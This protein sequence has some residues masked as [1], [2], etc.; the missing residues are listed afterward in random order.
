MTGT[1]EVNSITRQIVA[2]PT[3]RE[4]EDVVECRRQTVAKD[5]STM[6]EAAS[7][8]GIALLSHG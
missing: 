8:N 1:G 7:M 3:A 6:T 4:S 2:V 5:A